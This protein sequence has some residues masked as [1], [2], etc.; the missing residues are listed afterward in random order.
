MP[1]RPTTATPVARKHPLS[2][3]SE[4]ARFAARIN[5]A[6]KI[7]IEKHIVIITPRDVKSLRYQDIHL[8]VGR[9]ND[10]VRLGGFQKL[11]ID[12]GNC[13]E[14]EPVMQTALVGF[15]RAIPGGAAFCNVSPE[16]QES[17]HAARLL[18]L[19]PVFATRSDALKMMDDRREAAF[20]DGMDE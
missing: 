2:R 4:L 15:C 5:R 11:L 1:S 18:K 16:I 17:T 19:W 6:I 7:D 12:L 20:Q 13:R 9:I 10:L 8:E 14:I 3:I